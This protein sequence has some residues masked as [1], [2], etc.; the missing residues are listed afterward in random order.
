MSAMKEKAVKRLVP[1]NR[2]RLVHILHGWTPLFEPPDGEPIA[3]PV[4]DDSGAGRGIG[5]AARRTCSANLSS[6]RRPRRGTESVQPSE[7]SS[8]Y[9]LWIINILLIPIPENVSIIKR[10]WIELRRR[11]RVVSWRGR[12][13]T[14][15][16]ITFT[17]IVIARMK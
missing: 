7:V 11:R 16:M 13:S 17:P 1:S 12:V 8:L 14:S 6:P 2:I 3:R 10:K 4:T 9:L 15:G 5:T